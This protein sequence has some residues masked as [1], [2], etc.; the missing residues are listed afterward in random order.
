[1]LLATDSNDG[2]AE[3]VVRFKVPF[4]RTQVARSGAELW[5]NGGVPDDDSF[6]FEHEGAIVIARTAFRSLFMERLLRHRSRSRS[7]PHSDSHDVDVGESTCS[8]RPSADKR[9]P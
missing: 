8:I 4:Y 6:E 3:K 7:T 5:R 2:E 1:M 9:V